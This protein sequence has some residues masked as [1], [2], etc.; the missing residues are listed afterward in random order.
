MC[1]ARRFHRSL[2][3]ALDP[4]RMLSSSIGRE[5][6]GEASRSQ[7]AEMCVNLPGS[8]QQ[9]TD[10]VARAL[11][12]ET[13]GHMIR[14]TKAHEQFALRPSRWRRESF[15]RPSRKICYACT[16]SSGGGRKESCTYF[17]KHASSTCLS[18]KPAL[19]TLRIR[20]GVFS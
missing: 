20:P 1:I 6:Q 7:F 4:A 14:A 10:A 5:R 12:N 17:W 2:C 3:P 19:K 11:E 16:A 15:P 13:L 8:I 9:S 18:R